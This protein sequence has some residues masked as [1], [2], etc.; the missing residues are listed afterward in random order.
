[1]TF[2]T[3]QLVVGLKSVGSNASH[4][5]SSSP[6]AVSQNWCMSYGEL[7]DIGGAENSRVKGVW[8]FTPV[9]T[10]RM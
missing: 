9:S 10:V 7:S 6:F 3:L 4:T 5:S 8:V 2:T 1:M